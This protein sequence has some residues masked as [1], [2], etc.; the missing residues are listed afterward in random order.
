MVHR[1]RPDAYGLEAKGE[2][3]CGARCRRN[4]HRRILEGKEIKIFFCSTCWQATSFYASIADLLILGV[5]TKAKRSDQTKAVGCFPDETLA[6]VLA[7]VRPCD[8]MVCPDAIFRRLVRTAGKAWQPPAC[9]GSILFLSPLLNFPSGLLISC[10]TKLTASQPTSKSS[11]RLQ[12]LVRY[13]QTPKIHH[14][15]NYLDYGAG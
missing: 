4:G 11:A 2:S 14:L 10:W 15:Y 8:A 13:Q 7:K 12:Y 5:M 1:C 9:L 3:G 6:E